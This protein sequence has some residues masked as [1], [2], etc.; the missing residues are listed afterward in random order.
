MNSKHLLTLLLFFGRVLAR[1]GGPAGGERGR[2]RIYHGQV[3]PPGSPSFPYQ[4]QIVELSPDGKL[5]LSVCGATLISQRCES[6]FSWGWVKKRGKHGFSRSFITAAHCFFSEDDATGENTYTNPVTNERILVYGGMYNWCLESGVLFAKKLFCNTL[7]ILH[8]YPR[9][10][11]PGKSP[12]YQS[13]STRISF[14]TARPTLAM[15]S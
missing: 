3:D 4:L 15:A 9:Q 10:N 1:R 8:M 14:S 11:Q 6:Q 7:L 13:S 5:T 2:R 12:G